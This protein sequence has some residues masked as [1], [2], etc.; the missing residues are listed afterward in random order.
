MKAAGLAS[1]FK[2]SRLHHEHNCQI[3]SPAAFCTAAPTGW[4]QCCRNLVVRAVVLCLVLP[5]FCTIAWPVLLLP[6]P[7]FVLHLPLAPL[8]E[9]ALLHIVASFSS[10]FHLLLVSLPHCLVHPLLPFVYQV[11][12]AWKASVFNRIVSCNFSRQRGGT[13]SQVQW[14]VCMTSGR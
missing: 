10:T 11:P 5:S 4:E 6:V 8:I 2:L 1:A 9:Y 12:C 7:L 3:P 14:P 13:F